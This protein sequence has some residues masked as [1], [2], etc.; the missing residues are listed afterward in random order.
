MPN[1][2]AFKASFSRAR[3]QGDVLDTD[4][5]GGQQF[6]PLIDVEIP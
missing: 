4:S 3:S 6:T 1:A 2:L 5:H